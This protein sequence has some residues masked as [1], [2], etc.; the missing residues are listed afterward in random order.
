MMRAALKND[1]T[2]A[3]KLHYKLLPGY[4]LLFIENNPAGVKAF[5]SELN[6]IENVLRLPLVPLSPANHQKVKDFL[7]SIS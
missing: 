3:Q 4:D 7:A 6:L 1:F 2:T 5:M